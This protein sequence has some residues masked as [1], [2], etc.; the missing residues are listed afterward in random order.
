MSGYKVDEY[1][2]A[3]R[4]QRSAMTTLMTRKDNL[5]LL[6]SQSAVRLDSFKYDISKDFSVWK[7]RAKYLRPCDETAVMKTHQRCILIEEK[8]IYIESF[9]SCNNKSFRK[10]IFHIN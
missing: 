8:L 3:I 5:R 9:F 4:G 6:K 2:G 1:I 7:Y 10:L